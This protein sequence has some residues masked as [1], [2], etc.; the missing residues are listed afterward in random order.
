MQEQAL[1]HIPFLGLFAILKWNLCGKKTE[2]QKLRR[3]CIGWGTTVRLLESSNQN[4]CWWLEVW[5]ETVLRFLP[6]VILLPV[7]GKLLSCLVLVSNSVKHCFPTD[8]EV[9]HCWKWWTEK[10]RTEAMQA[11]TKILLCFLNLGFF[12][13]QIDFLIL[14]LTTQDI[15]KSGFKDTKHWTEESIFLMSNLCLMKSQNQQCPSHVVDKSVLKCIHR[16]QFGP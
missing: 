16:N 4:T 13:Y 8:L 7:V 2:G 3:Q 15:T 6:V 5:D 10:P 9:K 12:S 14:V 1:I 11:R